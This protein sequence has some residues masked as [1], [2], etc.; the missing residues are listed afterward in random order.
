M[1]EGLVRMYA[2]ESRVSIPSSGTVLRRCGSRGTVR[3]RWSTSQGR[4]GEGVEDPA[5]GHDLGRSLKGSP[6]KI[7]GLGRPLLD[8]LQHG[9]DD[10]FS[11]ILPEIEPLPD[12]FTDRFKTSGKF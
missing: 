4:A 8:V 12:P 2:I 11:N 6:G 5:C 7:S 10:L 3:K 1:N 9:I